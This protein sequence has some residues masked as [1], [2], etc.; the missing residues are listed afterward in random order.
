MLWRRRACPSATLDKILTRLSGKYHRAGKHREQPSDT[1]FSKKLGKFSRMLRPV[2]VDLVRAL[3]PPLLGLLAFLAGVRLRRLPVRFWHSVLTLVVSAIVVLAGALLLMQGSTAVRDWLGPVVYRLGGG[4]VLACPLGLLL[5]GVV[6]SQP[7]RST[8]SGFLQF[9]AGVALLVLTVESAGRLWWR[10]IDTRAWK[11]VPDQQ[12]C[13]QQTTWLTCGPA[14][15][16]MLL[17]RQGIAV[18][19]GELAYRAGTC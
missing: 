19:E 18:S 13:V 14:A 12:G 8:S 10:W 1:I 16:A 4:P 9:L 2:A 17:Q 6:W 5:L 15:S 3:M 7:G 11:N